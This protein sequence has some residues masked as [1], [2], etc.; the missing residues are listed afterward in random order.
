MVPVH[1]APGPVV[2][3][4]VHLVS[5]LTAAHV[6][7]LVVAQPGLR[8]VARLRSA[9]VRPGPLGVDDVHSRVGVPP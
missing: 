6:V 3:V 4:P 7:D 5:P 9:V 2:D 1:D 8:D